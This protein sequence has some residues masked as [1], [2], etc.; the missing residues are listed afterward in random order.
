MN[1][2]LPILIIVI[3][4]S[5]VLQ[6]QELSND[7][8][9]Q[10]ENIAETMEDTEI[11]DDS[12]LQHAE[13]LR[14]N[15]LNLN[16]AGED[17]LKEL[18]LLTPLQIAS[19]MDYRRLLGKL[20]SVYELQAVPFWDIPTIESLLPYVTIYSHQTLQE[21]FF[22]RLRTGEHRITARFSQV[23]TRAVG[24]TITDSGRSRY[25]GD[26]S[27]LMLRYHY[28]HQNNLQYGI[29]AS[30][31]AGEPFFVSPNRYGFDFHSF[32]YFSRHKGLVK[33]VALGD[34]TINFGQGLAHWQSMAFG[35]GNAA[36]HVKRQSQV[37]RPYNAAGSFFFNRGAAV[38]LQKGK[39]TSTVFTSI[40][41]LDGN[42][43]KNEQGQIVVTSIK[44]S[45]YHRT[46]AEIEDKNSLQQFSWGANLSYH[47][48]A[49]KIGFNT[50]HHHYDKPIRRES[51]LYNLHAISGSQWSNYSIDYALSYRNI[52]LFGETAL[53]RRGGWATLNSLIATLHT[54]ADFVLLHRSIQPRY[55]AMYGNAFTANTHPTNEHGTYAGLSLKPWHAIQINAYTD[56][57]RFPWLRYRTDAPASG[58]DYFVQINYKPNKLTELYSRFSIRHRPLNQFFEHNALYE[59]A[60][61]S[62][63]SWRTQVS[64]RINRSVTIRHRFEILWYHRENALQER[65]FL[66][67]IDCLYKPVGKRFSM[68]GRLQLFDSNSYNSRLYAYENDVLYHYAVPAFYD[69]GHRYYLNAQYRFSRHVQLWVKLAQTVYTSTHTIGSGLDLI[70]NNKKPEIRVLVSVRF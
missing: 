46:P 67:F 3:A 60:N 65:G 18:R 1:R 45:G 63:R 47:T 62:H 58:T 39:W 24:Y 31:D 66:A 70:E 64:H 25:M 14:K 61:T 8:E 40:R 53:D 48:T 11:T 43:E 59:A 9:Q 69:N 52:H 20:I 4:L 36:V 13:S 42:I 15:P 41:K 54:R 27:K 55:Q 6:A 10:L 35:K 16:T 50:I 17:D 2:L 38:T 34:Y 21:I 32:H 44:T 22:N 57:Y 68:N 49:F 37:L 56:V 26:P 23:L 33:T 7:L 5:P 19:F 29:T 12:W 51:K 28:Q 30:K